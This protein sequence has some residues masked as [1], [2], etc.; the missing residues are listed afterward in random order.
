MIILFIRKAP[1]LD[2][3]VSDHSTYSFEKHYESLLAKNYTWMFGDYRKKVEEYTSL[4]QDL[5]IYPNPC[6]K[7]ID[8]GCGSGFQSV[9]LAM[10][11]FEVLSID[12]NKTLL[13]ELKGNSRNH[14][15]TTIQANLLDF[16]RYAM[17]SEL[18]ICMGDTLSHLDSFGEIE[19]LFSNVLEN[20]RKK[21]KFL[22]SFRD[23][24]MELL[25]LDRI[26]PVQNDDN[27]IMT[28]FLEYTENSVFVHDMIYMK[29][30]H[31]WKLY[32]SYYKKLRITSIWIKEQ[33]KKLGFEI[34]HHET[35]TGFVYILAQKK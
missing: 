23:Y 27:K 1:V 34:I 19:R 12:L 13:D 17:D 22:I 9:A 14:K 30:H 7:A 5:G 20:L 11:G 6:N 4:F 2:A 8:L 21:G 32:K 26:I 3:S 10:L 18:I 31:G 33:F 35:L 28:T 15:I 16:A 24:S 29:E 25:G